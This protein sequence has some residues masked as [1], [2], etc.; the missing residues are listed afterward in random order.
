MPR[1]I[2]AD[3]VIERIKDKIDV[4]KQVA[5]STDSKQVKERVNH[6]VAVADFIANEIDRMAGTRR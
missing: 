6:E 2:D 3:L 1:M 4:L 5:E